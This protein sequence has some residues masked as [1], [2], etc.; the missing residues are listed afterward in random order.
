MT[1]HLPDPDLSAQERGR[2]ARHLTLPEFGVAGQ[3]RLKTASV[4]CVGAGGLGSPL[5]MYLAAAGVGRIGIVDDD[6][7][8]VSNLQRQVI[9]AE[10]GLGQLKTDSARQRIVGLNSHC[11]VEQH[12]CRLTT[13]NAI[14]LVEGHD[15]VVDGSD[16]F[17]TRYLINDVCA[18]LN[19]PWVYGSVQR[20]EGQVSVFNQ[21]PQSPD[22]RDLVPEPP[23]PGLVPS[24]SDGGVVGVMPGLIGLLQAT[25]TIKLLAGL[26]ESLDGRL[27][28]VDGLTMRFRELRLQR[29]PQRPPITGLIDYE[30]FCS[31]DNSGRL[32][33]ASSVRS[34]SVKELSALLDDGGELVL[35][36]VRNPSEADVAVI[37][38]SQLIPL[39]QIENGE[40]IEEIRRLA[41]QGPIYVH[42]KLGGRSARAVELLSQQGIDA[43]NVAGGIDAWSQQVDPGVVRY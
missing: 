12:A 32:E 11:R 21:G 38:R 18:L 26:G 23:P 20:F 1:E 16:N 29:R 17:P 8:E 33:G 35:I 3:R 22:Y 19:K 34:I 31:V 30:A 28:L 43:T 2:Y 27:L 9:H 41:G 4:L 15:L 39:A 42:C 10:S 6:R 36:D 7:V 25:E 40:R 37:P 5:L 13:T 24:C 14:E